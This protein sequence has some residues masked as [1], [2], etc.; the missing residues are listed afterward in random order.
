MLPRLFGD[1]GESG[2]VS[3]RFFRRAFFLFG[4]A[5]DLAFFLRRFFAGA[6]EAAFLFFR[7]EA[8]LATFFF[9]DAFLLF[10]L[11]GAFLATA[12]LLLAFL[13]RLDDLRFLRV[14]AN[15]NIYLLL[16]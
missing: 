8:F 12:F 11:L 4:F 5:A 13:R 16:M 14:E 2:T 15:P 7:R 6:L 3:Y 9:A 1:K 10:F